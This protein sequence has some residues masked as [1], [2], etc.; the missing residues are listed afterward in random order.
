MVF[1]RLTER[2]QQIRQTLT[3]PVTKIYMS[4]VID[5]AKNF[6]YFV[7]PLQSG[8][9]KIY[10]LHDKSIKLISDIVLRLVDNNE[11]IPNSSGNFL[12]P[13]EDLLK[14]LKNKKKS[15]GNMT[16]HIIITDWM[17]SKW[18]EMF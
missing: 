18:K 3:N 13:K 11:N 4:L 6:K 1:E 5:I 17:G 12:L 14:V 16:V 7:L 2:Y 9:P 10:V 8:E 15:Q